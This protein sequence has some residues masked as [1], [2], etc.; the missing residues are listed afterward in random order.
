MML[1]LIASHFLDNPQPENNFTFFLQYASR[2]RIFMAMKLN[3]QI[4][5]YFSDI[6]RIGGKTGTGKA[7]ARTSEQA[8]AAVLA[9]WNKPGA[10]KPRQ[11]KTVK[12]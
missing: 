4:R 11:S 9:R 8:R 7:K 3:N 10:R 1:P 6:G 2:L 5:G 12:K